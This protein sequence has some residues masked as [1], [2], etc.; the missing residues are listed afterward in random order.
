[1]SSFYCEYD[2]GRQDFQMNSGHTSSGHTYNLHNKTSAAA[3]TSTNHFHAQNRNSGSSILPK[4]EMGDYFSDSHQHFKQQ[5][6]SDYTSNT[7]SFGTPLPAKEAEYRKTTAVNGEYPNQQNHGSHISIHQPHHIINPQ[8]IAHPNF[9]LPHFRRCN[10]DESTKYFN[11]STVTPNTFY[12]SNPRGILLKSEPSSMQQIPFNQAPMTPN[13]SQLSWD[14]NSRVKTQIPTSNNSYSPVQEN[15]RNVGLLNSSPQ[16]YPFG[17]SSSSVNSYS[18]IQPRQFASSSSVP[19]MTKDTY[20]SHS[21]NRYESSFGVSPNLY[22]S[23]RKQTNYQGSSNMYPTYQPNKSLQSSNS[24]SASLNTYSST[25]ANKPVVVG[26]PYHSSSLITETKLRSMLIAPTHEEYVPMKPFVSTQQQTQNVHC[27]PS[28]YKQMLPNDRQ[29]NLEL[30]SMHRKPTPASSSSEYVSNAFKQHSYQ[31]LNND[32]QRNVFGDSVAL[33][34]ASNS[35]TNVQQ[36]A[37]DQHEQSKYGQIS[38]S[39]IQPSSRFAHLDKSQGP[40]FNGTKQILISQRESH[41]VDKDKK[42][43][44]NQTCHSCLPRQINNYPGKSEMPPFYRN[45]ENILEKHSKSVGSGFRNLH[46]ST[47]NESR[48][49]LM[50]YKT[51]MF[52]RKYS[53]SKDAGQLNRYSPGNIKQFQL[54]STNT[55][56]EKVK[57][58]GS[59]RSKNSFNSFIAPESNIEETEHFKFPQVIESPI[60]FRTKGEL[61]QMCPPP[62]QSERQDP[63]LS[64]DEWNTWSSSFSNEWEKFMVNLSAMK[65]VKRVYR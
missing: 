36:N 9:S 16:S 13:F 6:S 1:M 44:C 63:I 8:S 60:K 47:N 54:E 65:N 12:S 58:L 28:V 49:N 39:K 27:Y 30:P 29:Q 35:I 7:S 42:C 15:Y 23:I 43:N 38:E 45:T 11:N 51:K 14:T 22:P 33:P 26:M 53:S 24:A 31:H 20:S 41:P 55:G 56:R 62:A 61:K 52:V 25:T 19:S 5:I 17:N 10:T 32:K 48:P 59:P 21:M 4:I 18:D 3:G 34:T 37:K 2:Q 40:H 46:T 50:Q 64:E 57:K